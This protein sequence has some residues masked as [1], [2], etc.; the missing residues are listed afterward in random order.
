M[1]NRELLNIIEEMGKDGGPGIGEIAAKA[2]LNRSHLSTFI[3]LKEEKQA[4]PAMLRKLIKAY[5][6]VFD[7]PYKTNI[8]EVSQNGTDKQAIIVDYELFKQLI[9]EKEARRLD[10][11]EKAKQVREDLNDAKEEKKELLNIIKENLTALLLSSTKNQELL[12]K[13]WDEQTSDD[14]VMM[15]NDDKAAGDPI[16]TSAGKADRNLLKLASARK[17]EQQK[18]GKGK[19]A[20]AG[21]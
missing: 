4:S 1:N 12:I 5:P 19:S 15:N 11:E 8:L 16:G 21:K 9:A 2:G 10:A 18:T 13:I 14:L 7:E 17:E 3:N 20:K 6:G